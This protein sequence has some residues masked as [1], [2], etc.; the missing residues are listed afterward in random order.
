MEKV[1]GKKVCKH[2]ARDGKTSQLLPVTDAKIVLTMMAPSTTLNLAGPSQ[3]PTA[4]LSDPQ[5]SEDE[6]ENQNPFSVPQN[7][8]EISLAALSLSFEG[9]S[10]S[11]EISTKDGYGFRPPSGVNTPMRQASLS[12]ERMDARSPIPDVNGLG[13]PGAS[14]HFRAWQ[15]RLTLHRNHSFCLTIL[16]PRFSEHVHHQF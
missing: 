8:D 11:R 6:V 13:W 15:P 7:S 10:R 2:C 3:R 9:R 14:F 5:S 16:S 4:L 1:L 12:L